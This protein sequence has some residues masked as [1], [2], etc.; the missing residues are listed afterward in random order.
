MIL[1]K[2]KTLLLRFTKSTQKFSQFV[3]ITIGLKLK[4]EIKKVSK[5]ILGEF[6]LI[7]KTET[8]NQKPETGNYCCST[9][10]VKFH[11]ILFYTSMLLCKSPE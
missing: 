10:N 7:M 5:S 1:V 9:N 8:R 11:Y 4:F 3:T 2:Y 6:Y